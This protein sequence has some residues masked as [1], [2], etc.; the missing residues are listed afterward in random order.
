[1]AY[2]TEQDIYDELGLCPP[3]SWESKT[4]KKVIIKVRGAIKRFLRYDFEYKYH[5]EYYPQRDYTGRYLTAVETISGAEMP[6]RITQATSEFIVQHIPV[7]SVT[8][9]WVDD[10]AWSET[11]SPAFEAS[12]LKVEG[13]DFWPNWNLSIM[14]GAEKVCEDG[15]IRS[16]SQWPTFPGSIKI[17]YWAGYTDAELRGESEYIDASPIWEALLDEASRRVKRTL[18]QR[19]NAAG[20]VDWTAGPIQSERLGDYSYTI[21]SGSSGSAS[22][23]SEAT[24]TYGNSHELLYTTREKLTS[25]VNYGFALSS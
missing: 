2:L 24:M 17:C 20:N 15:I 4:V 21:G 10:D 13:T 25:Y 11:K 1:M 9:L 18:M 23:A 3:N 14:S 19:K 6:G 7:R 16:E 8:G 12:Q 22:S 5:C